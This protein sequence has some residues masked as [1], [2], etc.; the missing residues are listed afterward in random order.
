MQPSS[1]AEKVSTLTQTEDL[2]L[3]HTVELDCNINVEPQH[4]KVIS[5]TNEIHFA[6]GGRLMG[7][8]LHLLNNTN[9]SSGIDT[10]SLSPSVS[11]PEKRSSLSNVASIDSIQVSD[12]TTVTK[13]Q[14]E[15]NP[16]VIGP[17]GIDSS[18]LKQ[19][20]SRYPR[21]VPK[22]NLAPN[23]IIT[24]GLIKNNLSSKLH[25]PK[26]GSESL[27]SSR[28]SDVNREQRIVS[29]FIKQEN[30]E[31]SV[32]QRVNKSG[33]DGP[34]DK[35]SKKHRLQNINNGKDNNECT[36]AKCIKGTKNQSIKDVELD[37]YVEQVTCYKCKFCHFLALEK[38]GVVMH[39]QLVHG[40]QL[41]GIHR[42]TRHHIKC[43]GCENVFFSSKSLKVHLSHDHQVGDEELKML[44]DV[45]IRSSYKDAKAK[46]KFDKKRKRSMV[47]TRSPETVNLVDNACSAG[48]EMPSVNGVMQVVSSATDLLLDECSKIRVRDLNS[49]VLPELEDTHV[50]HSDTTTT[51]G[52]IRNEDSLISSAAS[53]GDVREGTL[54][55]DDNH[56]TQ[57][58]HA[59]ITVDICEFK[60]TGINLLV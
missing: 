18:T 7:H 30:F 2:E 46:N 21:I 23:E 53:D 27:T 35:G 16:R 8:H 56:L 31:N 51:T 43:P 34:K 22:I 41:L 4:S 26:H 17:V 14:V 52:D 36:N 37:S 28:G 54:V 32:N 13:H 25:I 9:G 59:K 5:A 33:G 19:T 38:G 1:S 3:G 42:E 49:E 57:Q 39:V 6:R 44:V 11:L 29:V 12:E 24:T 47:T 48:K 40:S 45:V 20:L 50:S 10:A 60:V 58:K 15:V 55:I